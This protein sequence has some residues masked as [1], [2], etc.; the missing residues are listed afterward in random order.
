LAEVLAREYRLKDILG[1]D[2]IA[3]G[4]K[5]DPGPAFPL[6]NIRGRILGRRED[7]DDTYKVKVEGLN[8]RSGPGVQYETVAK[9]LALDVRLTVF[10]I[11][12]RWSMVDVEGDN[13]IEGWV[14]NK[15][16]EMV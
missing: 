3:P 9:P 2:D 6:T 5:N 12:D 15:Y 10:E 8:I 4:R 14:Y 16:I 1:H 13:D 7:A 11:R